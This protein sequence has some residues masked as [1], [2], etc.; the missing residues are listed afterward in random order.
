MMRQATSLMAA[1]LFVSAIKAG[2]QQ[3]RTEGAISMLEVVRILMSYRARIQAVID[4]PVGSTM[5][6]AVT[7]TLAPRGD[8]WEIWLDGVMREEFSSRDG[9]VDNLRLRLDGIRERGDVGR[10][11]EEKAPPAAGA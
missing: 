1:L 8:R 11:I 5:A 3:Q 10:W 4:R 9:A 6:K 7:F 2:A